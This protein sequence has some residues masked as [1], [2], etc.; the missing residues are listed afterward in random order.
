[1]LVVIHSFV[2]VMHRPL[3]LQRM[4]SVFVCLWPSLSHLFSAKLSLVF[5][6]F[7][8]MWVGW[9]IGLEKKREKI[10]PSSKLCLKTFEGKSSVDNVTRK[11]QRIYR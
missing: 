6:S 1:M 7:A 4:S 5:L 9:L 11:S 3:G 10:N 2:S 8:F